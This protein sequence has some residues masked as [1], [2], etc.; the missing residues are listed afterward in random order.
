LF[1]EKNLG[2]P[3][4]FILGLLAD[5]NTRTEAAFLLLYYNFIFVLPLICINCLVYWGVTT[6]QH[7]GNWKDKYIRYLHLI[8]GLILIALGAL[9]IVDYYKPLF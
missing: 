1:L 4:L 5:K 3:Y 7:V 8:A 6:V 9:A 2:G